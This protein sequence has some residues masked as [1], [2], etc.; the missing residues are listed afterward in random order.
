MF[1]CRDGTWSPDS[2]ILAVN[3]YG[4]SIE[5]AYD[6][7]RGRPV[8]FEHVRALMSYSIARTYQVTSEQ[9]RQYGGDAIEWAIRDDT[10]HRLYRSTH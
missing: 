10:A 9:L 3:G 1:S 7:T 6:V 4:R 2:S 8:A 5:A